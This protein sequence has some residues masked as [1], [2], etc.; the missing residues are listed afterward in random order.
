MA[1]WVTIGLAIGALV[2]SGQDRS[3]PPPPGAVRTIQDAIEALGERRPSRAYPRG[4]ALRGDVG[5]FFG[6][7][8]YP[9]E[10]VAAHEQG[11]V[12]ARLN[13]GRDGRV[14]QCTVATSSGSVA[15]DRRT[16][17]IASANVTFTPARDERGRTIASTYTLP[18][19]WVL[20]DRSP[21]TSTDEIITL[22]LDAGGRVTDCRFTF[23]GQRPTGADP[24][25]PSFTSAPGDSLRSLTGG[26]AGIVT[27]QRIV[28][29]AGQPPIPELF[30]AADQAL[31]QLKRVSF[32]V[33]PDG[34]KSDVRVI[35]TSG[36]GTLPDP[37]EGLD[38]YMAEPGRTDE[39]RVTSGVS[40][41]AAR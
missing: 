27:L 7:D 41:K 39:V 25:C 33:G 3:A 38:D 1:G 32:Q 9:A 35:T 20:P 24:I 21:R 30:T 10:A 34:K 2:T 28:Q 4:A 31:V 23:N 6:P 36:V 40:F 19:R 22:R 8:D 37:S 14:V 29:F 15:L 13:V 18:V 17:E 26:R 5:R 11:R 16:C 12:I